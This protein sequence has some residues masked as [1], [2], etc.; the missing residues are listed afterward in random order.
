M[1]Y[2]NCRPM[3]DTTAAP[4]NLLNRTP[5][6]PC[7]DRR[8]VIG[9]AATTQQTVS[10][11][12]SRSIHAKQ[13]PQAGI[14]IELCVPI[15]THQLG[16]SSTSIRIIAQCLPKQVV[17]ITEIAQQLAIGEN[18][19]LTIRRACRRCCWSARAIASAGPGSGHP[20]ISMDLNMPLNT[21]RRDRPDHGFQS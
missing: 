1:R 2:S 13:V 20:R 10:R 9:A 4:F 5:A 12:M 7:F 6:R 8:G 16:A 3:I 21:G 11:T 14:H 15:V 19:A 18:T 17:Q